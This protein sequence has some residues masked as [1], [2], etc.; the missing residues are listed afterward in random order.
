MATYDEK[1]LAFSTISSGTLYTPAVKGL[2]H[3][4]ILH[5]TGTSDQTVTLALN[6]G[7]VFRNLYK[8]VL[9]AY[10]TVQLAYVNEGIVV[11]PSG[12]FAGHTT[13]TGTVTIGIFGSEVT[14]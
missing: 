1:S 4:I 8:V 9:A 2:I 13:T 7:V 11:N 10:E 3:N 14:P 12:S 6:N 5:N